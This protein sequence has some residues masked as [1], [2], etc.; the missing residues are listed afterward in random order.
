MFFNLLP[1]FMMNTRDQ[2]FKATSFY[3]NSWVGQ[4]VSTPQKPRAAYLQFL[5]K[6]HSF[7]P[8]PV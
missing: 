7:Q 8:H 4:I 5:L 1:V 3:C 2:L 6:W